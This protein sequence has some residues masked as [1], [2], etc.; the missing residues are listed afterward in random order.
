MEH[1]ERGSPDSGVDIEDVEH[2]KPERE[3]LEVGVDPTCDQKVGCDLENLGPHCH[4]EQS[5]L[6]NPS[7]EDEKEDSNENLLLKDPT[8]TKKHGNDMKAPHC[9]YLDFEMKQNSRNYE[10]YQASLISTTLPYKRGFFF[11]WLATLYQSI[12]SRKKR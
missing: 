5:A 10:V 12:Q 7:I 9:H 2:K 3:A 4:E 11:Q 6:L 8:C 1:S